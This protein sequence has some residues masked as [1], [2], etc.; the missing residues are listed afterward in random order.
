MRVRSLVGSR[1]VASIVK[2]RK[3]R[4]EHHLSSLLAPFSLF[5]HLPAQC[6]IHRSLWEIQEVP[7]TYDRL[8]FEIIR[9]T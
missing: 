2:F 8:L 3:F 5:G 9:E 4:A 1:R 6:F 7:L